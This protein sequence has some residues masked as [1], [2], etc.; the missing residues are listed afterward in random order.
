M[1]KVTIAHIV[2]TLRIGGMETVVDNILRN[3]DKKKYRPIAICL[4]NIGPI[5]QE[6]LIN[7]FNVY[8]IPKMTPKLSFVYPKHLIDILRHEKVEIIHAHSGCWY[9]A[10]IACKFLRIK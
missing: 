3:T 8:K 10:A 9:K 2:P 1:K 4:K 5:G 7:N 6:L